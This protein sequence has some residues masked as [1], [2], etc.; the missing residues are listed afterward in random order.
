MGVVGYGIADF[1]DVETR[2]KWHLAQTGMQQFLTDVG[3][4]ENDATTALYIF[5][6]ATTDVERTTSE[7]AAATAKEGRWTFFTTTMD[8]KGG[9][10]VLAFPTKGVTPQNIG[11]APFIEVHS[12]LAGWWLVNAWRGQQLADATW[13][14][15][16][17]FAIIPSA[18]CARAL[19][20]TAAAF[21]YDARRLHGLWQG[22]KDEAATTGPTLEHWHSLVI[23]LNQ[24]MWGGKFDGR[25]PDLAESWGGIERVNVLT[26]VER[27]GRATTPLV[28]HDYQWLCNAVH[29]SVGG[30]L[31][32]S[33]PFVLHDT[34]THA[35]NWFAPFPMHLEQSGTVSSVD[36]V[37]AALARTAIIA[38]DVLMRTLDDVLRLID[39]IGLT[40][41]APAR[42]TFAYWRRVVSTGRNQPCPCR[43]GRKVKECLHRWQDAAPTVVERFDN[44]V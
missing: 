34:K 3:A 14:L 10:K 28:Q 43:S 30:T 23:W 40:T 16:N 21:W 22:V 26:Q 42:A 13:K 32:F 24:T 41:G 8:N 39:D 36:T 19:L 17:T 37:H 27:L 15:G 33:S 12:R 4:P 2:R 31:A 20:E 11:A 35:F 6:I 5:P 18:A 7:L 9:R 44:E 38:V 25:V 1:L 29:P